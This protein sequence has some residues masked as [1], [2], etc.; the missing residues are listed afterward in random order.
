MP[1]YH[2]WH[3][4]ILNKH[5]HTQSI[6][7]IVFTDTLGAAPGASN[8]HSRPETS[9]KFHKASQDH[10]LFHSQPRKNLVAAHHCSE[11]IRTFQ[12]SSGDTLHWE[13]AKISQPCFYPDLE[14]SSAC[15]SSLRKTLKISGCEIVLDLTDSVTC[16]CTGIPAQ[17]GHGPDS[18]GIQEPSG[19]S[20]ASPDATNGQ[21][22]GSLRLKPKLQMLLGTAAAAG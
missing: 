16:S 15:Y 21:D 18:T 20:W 6:S 1:I 4:A 10:S 11:C 12:Q 17:Q 8:I 19:S 14:K 2:L 13:K 7:P 22:W 5:T 3:E 9:S